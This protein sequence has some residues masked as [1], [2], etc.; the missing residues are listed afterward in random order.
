MNSLDTNVLVYAANASCPEHEAALALVEKMLANPS[1]WILA[2]QVLWEFYKALRHPRIL[3]KP[4]TASQAAAHVRF[5]RETSGVAFCAYDPH[6]FPE[7]IARL[8]SKQFPYQRTHDVVLGATLRA[9]GV[10]VFYT[11]NTKD[12]ADAGFTRLIDPFS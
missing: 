10:K 12:F 7:I 4:R 8:E 2:D 9:N 6:C 5:L 11:R 3:E 1:D